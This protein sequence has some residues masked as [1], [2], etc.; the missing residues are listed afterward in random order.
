LLKAG[1]VF[2]ISL[3][4]HGRLTRTHLEKKLI[5]FQSSFIF[6]P[7]IDLPISSFSL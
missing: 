4:M 7:G 2:A 5:E 6:S 1:Q 3:M